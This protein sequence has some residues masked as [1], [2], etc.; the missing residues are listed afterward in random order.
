MSDESMDAKRLR[1]SERVGLNVGPIPIRLVLALTFLWAGV[2]KF[3]AT[4]PVSGEDALVLYEMGAMSA[5]GG[6][7]EALS[8]NAS[9]TQP[10]GR[11]V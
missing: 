9:P 11:Q 3:A 7:A 8:I 1:F 4:F 2:G 10:N 5:P 6:E